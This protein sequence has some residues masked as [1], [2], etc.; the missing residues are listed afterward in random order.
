M[1]LYS[2]C[3]LTAISKSKFAEHLAWLP[4][5]CIRARGMICSCPAD[6]HVR[7][8]KTASVLVLFDAHISTNSSVARAHQRKCQALGFSHYLGEDT[9]WMMYCGP[10][11]GKMASD[12]NL[13]NVIKTTKA[14]LGACA[15]GHKLFQ[16]NMI[17]QQN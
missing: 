9:H 14:R 17:K 15:N 6:T 11:G 1:R 3:W 16:H 10:S 7:G 4:R 5:C 13:K 12:L 2:I 8:E